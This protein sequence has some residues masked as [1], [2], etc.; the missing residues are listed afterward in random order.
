MTE[1]EPI[2]ADDPLLAMDGVVVTPHVGSA[3]RG[4][5]RAMCMLAA[6]NLLA[7]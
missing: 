2:A 1:P 5:R 4:S 3:A 7:A 6:R